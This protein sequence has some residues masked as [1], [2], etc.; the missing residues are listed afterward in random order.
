MKSALDNAFLRRLR[1]TV[2][3]PFPGV[4]ERV[5]IWRGIFPSATP[6]DSLDFVKLAQL[7]VSGGHIRNIA[8]SAAFFAADEGHPVR[9][10]HLLKAARAESAKLEHVLSEAEVSGWA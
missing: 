6:V 5:A 1:F 8:L 10:T 7:N 9:M 4:P 3:F 2:E